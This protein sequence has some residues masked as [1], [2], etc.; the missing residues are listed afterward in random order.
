MDK[1][2]S[3]EKYEGFMMDF[4]WCFKGGRIFDRM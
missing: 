4:I 1:F 3:M 2:K